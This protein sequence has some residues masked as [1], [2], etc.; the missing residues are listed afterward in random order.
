MVLAT[1]NGKCFMSKDMLSHL[2]RLTDQFFA[3]LLMLISFVSVSIVF[4]AS[5]VWMGSFLV[6]TAYSVSVTTMPLSVTST[7]FVR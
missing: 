4:L 1:V 5:T 3:A 2:T 6:E 7:A